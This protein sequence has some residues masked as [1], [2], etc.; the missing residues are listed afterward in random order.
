M[1]FTQDLFSAPLYENSHSFKGKNASQINLRMFPAESL[2]ADEIFMQ[3]KHGA[4]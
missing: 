1:H 4:L 2:P 3:T